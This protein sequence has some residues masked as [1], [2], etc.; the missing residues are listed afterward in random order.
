M[1]HDT[2]LGLF[3]TGEE[4]EYKNP[5]SPPH[6]H[7]QW[8]LRLIDFH[9]PHHPA[10]SRNAVFFFALIFTYHVVRASTFGVFRFFDKSVFFFEAVRSAHCSSTGVFQ[11][12]F[13]GHSSQLPVNDS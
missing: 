11:T 1:C 13:V 8:R 3:L 2:A 6:C 12:S 7:L 10:W 9:E 5:R 4:G